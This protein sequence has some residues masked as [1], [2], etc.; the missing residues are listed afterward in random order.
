[1]N[2]QTGLVASRYELRLTS[3]S[4]TIESLPAKFA[5]RA[6][7]L[8]LQLEKSHAADHSRFQQAVKR[9]VVHRAV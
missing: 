3:G 9:S 2:L 6:T 1:M 8:F 4:A 5:G 7:H